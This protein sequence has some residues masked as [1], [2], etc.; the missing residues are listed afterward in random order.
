MTTASAHIAILD[1]IGAH[2]GMHYY[3][4]NQATA[5]VNAGH[6]VTVYSLPSSTD[7]GARYAKVQTFRRIYGKESKAIRG[8]RFLR[9]IASVLFSA[10][11]RGVKLL[12]HHLFKMD[13]FDLAI[14]A[15]ARKLGMRTIAV[16]HDVERLDQPGSNANLAAIARNCDLMAVHNGFSETALRR[17][18]GDIPANIAV[19]PSGNF[20]A[21]FPAPP[22]KSDARRSLGLPDQQVIVLFFGNPRREKGLHVLLEAAIAHKDS[23][24]LLILVAGKMKPE[25]EAEYRDFLAKYGLERRVRFDIGHVAD[26]AVP[27]YYRAA[28]IVALPYLRIYESGVAMMAMSLDRPILA[29]DLQPF[30]EIIGGEEAENGARGLLFPVNDAAALAARVSEI[31]QDTTQLNSFSYNAGAYASKQRHWDVTGRL[32]SQAISKIC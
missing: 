11:R 18:M 5:L 27:N 21:Q 8:L 14:L 1:A 16:V 28:D 32:L 31:L 3:T 25:E 29:S 30:R 2:G 9:D 6:P 10:R 22:S 26:D 7:E 13:R 23:D 19:I 24:G 4:D 15:G 12:I 20:I 17:V